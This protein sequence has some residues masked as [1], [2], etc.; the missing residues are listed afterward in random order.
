MKVFKRKKSIPT[1]A[2]QTDSSDRITN[3][4][5]A[6]HREQ[7]LA[8]GRRFKYP[9]QYARIKLVRN[10]AIIVLVALLL[11]ALVTW[12]QLYPAQSTNEF[13][14]RITRLLPLPVAKVQNENV[15]YS[16]YLLTLRSAMYFL[17]TNNNTNFSTDD[18]RRQLNYLKRGALD[19]AIEYGF[20][21]K[22]A[23]DNNISISDQEV[24]TFYK[25]ILQQ[26]RLTTNE[27]AYTD[28]IQK[29]Y[30]WTFDEFKTS[31]RGKL[32][33]N[34]VTLAIDT[35][36]K[37]KIESLQKQL[38]TGADFTTIVKANSDD[39][40]AA[41]SGGDQGQVPKNSQD[42]SGL[43]AAAIKLQP[44]QI[45]SILHDSDG[46][47]LIKLID[48]N[49]SQVHYAR[50]FVAFKEFNKRLQDAKDKGQV[51]EYISVPKDVAPVKQ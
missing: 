9:V 24:E 14:Y 15:P 1:T 26:N 49:D 33:K 31:A 21:T 45:S 13:F 20:A 19:G 16:Y 50:I 10:T 29:Y 22:L 46:Y 38:Q 11:S 28:S 42:A 34:K 12:W 4:T 23:R 47:Y 27:S 40:E 37:A 3:E 43:V 25:N 18:G 39:P 30:G 5:V 2:K 41:Q 44:G 35:T 6:E 51:Q 8:G 36:A 32:L 48:S 17:E 7:I